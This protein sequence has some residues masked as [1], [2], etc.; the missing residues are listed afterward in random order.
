MAGFKEAL[1]KT[2]QFEGGYSFDPLDSGGETYAGISRVHHPD[3]DGWSIVD[4]IKVTCGEFREDASSKAQLAIHVE[5]FYFKIWSDLDSDVQMSETLIGVLF[6]TTV[7][8][9][10]MRAVRFLQEAMN[11]LNRNGTLWPDVAIDGLLGPTTKHVLGAIPA[12]HGLLSR[13]VVVIRGAFYLSIVKSNPSQERFIRGWLTR[14][15]LI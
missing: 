4:A 12:E 9:G 2:L 14:I 8:M 10:K 11:V 1:T 7:N 6:D 3:W 15:E 13:I 5:S